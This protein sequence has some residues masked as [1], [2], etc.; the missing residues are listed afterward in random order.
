MHLGFQ[1]GFKTERFDRQRGEKIFSATFAGLLEADFRAPSCDYATFHKLVGMFTRGNETDIRQ[2]YRVMCFNVLTHNR[3]DHAKNFAFLYTE[4]QGWRLAPAYDMTYSDTYWGEHT[5]SVN[6]K[7]KDITLE[8]M[9]KVGIEA[10][11]PKK[12]CMDSLT[13]IQDAAKELEEYIR[14]PENKESAGISFEKRLE[15]FVNYH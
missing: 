15:E 6:G 1:S 11:L 4:D 9:Y 14:K 13:E 2:L 8:D 7:G 3:D 12:Y 5:T 10:G